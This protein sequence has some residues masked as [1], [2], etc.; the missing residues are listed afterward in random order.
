MESFLWTAKGDVEKPTEGDLV[1][2]ITLE[3]SG[4]SSHVAKSILGCGEEGILAVPERSFVAAS[5]TRP[6]RHV[7]E[8]NEL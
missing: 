3:G 5:N 2:N 1:T 4:G 6:F 7:D 8:E